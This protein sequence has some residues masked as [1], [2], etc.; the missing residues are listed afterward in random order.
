[1]SKISKIIT[2]AILA[3][4]FLQ[5]AQPKKM[6]QN[7]G[8][9]AALKKIKGLSMIKAK[10]VVGETASTSPVVNTPENPTEFMTSSAV[11]T[12]SEVV[13]PPVEETVPAT[14]TKPATVTRPVVVN[15]LNEETPAVVEEDYCEEE[16]EIHIQPTPDN[17]PEPNNNSSTEV[18]GNESYEGG[19]G[20][21]ANFDIP[22]LKNKMKKN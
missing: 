6:K 3:I 9:V 21:S 7:G 20:S 5:T 2:I 1:M 15:T 8:V 16:P 4:C 19:E 10:Q 22:L 13:S 12:N 14:T 18:N 11:A 17:Q